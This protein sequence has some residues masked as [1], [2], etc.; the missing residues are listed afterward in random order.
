MGNLTGRSTLNIKVEAVATGQFRFEQK[1][2][3]STIYTKF[4]THQLVICP[5]VIQF[6]VEENYSI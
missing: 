2:L 5:T 6:D 1:T 4:S 3:D